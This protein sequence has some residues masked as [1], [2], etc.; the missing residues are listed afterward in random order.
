MSKFKYIIIF[1]L[2]YFSSPNGL[3]YL[4]NLYINYFLKDVF[5]LTATQEAYFGAISILGWVIK[6]VW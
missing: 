1:A 4:P 6:P 2:V 3:S 5:K